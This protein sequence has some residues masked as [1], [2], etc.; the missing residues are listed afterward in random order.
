MI[1]FSLVLIST[2]DL[3]YIFFVQYMVYGEEGPASHWISLNKYGYF[4]EFW[5]TLE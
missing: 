4:R 2:E 5:S 3:K 1:L